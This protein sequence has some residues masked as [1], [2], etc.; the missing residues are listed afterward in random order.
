VTVE[1]PSVAAGK[2]VRV[3]ADVGTSGRGH[4]AARILVAARTDA[5]AAAE[6][7]YPSLAL[8][9]T[10]VSRE[11]TRFEGEAGR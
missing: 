5:P 8:T 2:R 7:R 6:A 9:E 1:A 3:V 10:T 11:P 4:P